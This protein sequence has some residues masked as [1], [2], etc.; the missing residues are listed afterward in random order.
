MPARRRALRIFLLVT[1]LGACAAQPDTAIQFALPVDAAMT[2]LEEAERVVEGTGMGSLSL[3]AESTEGNVM[4]ITLR[5][6]GDRAAVPCRV[7]FSAV[8]DAAS[9]ADLD[10]RQRQG[11]DPVAQDVGTQAVTLVMREHVLAAVE[12][13][14][15]DIDGV[16]NGVI[17]LAAT[18]GPKL[19]AAMHADKPGDDSAR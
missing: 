3:D 19:A 10:C 13:R 4:T 15:Y 1:G 7:T 18:N 5:R 9:R 6:A 12:N 8:S 11:P 16:A 17:M 14:D 2:R